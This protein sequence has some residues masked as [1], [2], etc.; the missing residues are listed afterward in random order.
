VL[1]DSIDDLALSRTDFPNLPPGTRAIALPD[2][3]YNQSAPFL[4]VF[5]RPQNESVCE[6]ERTQSSSLAQSLHLM[7]AGDIRGKLAGGGHR[8]DQLAKAQTPIEDRVRELYLRAFSRPPQPA[9]L[10]TAVEFVTAPQTDAAGNPIDPARATHE[11]F[12]D[13]IWALINT[14]EFQFNH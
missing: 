13:L 2:N 8:A 4:R 10:Q 5:G 7:N 1:L 6:C 14:R 12:Q 11:A 3:S 9:E